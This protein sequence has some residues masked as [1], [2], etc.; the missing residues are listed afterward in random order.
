MFGYL[1]KP[2]EDQAHGT[3]IFVTYMHSKPFIVQGVYNFWKSWNST[4][5]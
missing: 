2:N 1:S 3:Q 5:I 4:S